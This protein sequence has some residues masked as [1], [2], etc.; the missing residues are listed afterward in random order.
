[1]NQGYVDHKKLIERHNYYKKLL[2]N[3]VVKRE[4]NNIPLILTP[5][6]SGRMDMSLFGT[7]GFTEVMKRLD[8]LC[9]N[10]N[11]KEAKKFYTPKGF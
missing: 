2:G 1:M 11:K 7:S 3:P 5:D 6:P 4:P 10:E 8:A 9:S